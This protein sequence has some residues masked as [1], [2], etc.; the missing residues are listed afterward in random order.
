MT[1]SLCES[2]QIVIFIFVP[3]DGFSQKGKAFLRRK[4]L[5]GQRMQTAGRRPVCAA[6]GDQQ[7]QARMSQAGQHVVH[8]VHGFEVIQHQQGGDRL[9]ST[10]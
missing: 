2:F 10:C 6:G 8:L 9:L 5:E 1:E 4:Q 7:V 3:F